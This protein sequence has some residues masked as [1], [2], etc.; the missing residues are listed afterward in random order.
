M[1]TEQKAREDVLRGFEI[2]NTR[3]M[4][5]IDRWYDELLA[6]DCVY[7]NP[8]VRDLA[9]GRES[10][11]QFVRALYK[12]MP[13]LHHNAPDDLIVQGD[14][15]AVRYTVRRTDPATGKLQTCMILL[16]ERYAGD[17]IAEMWELVGPWEDEG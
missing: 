13:D 5:V 17:K 14:K 15:V 11:K 16:I 3:D 12:A 10:I 1:V 2:Y 8:G 7:H 6:P 4:S 9:P